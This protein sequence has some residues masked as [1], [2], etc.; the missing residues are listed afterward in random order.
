MPTFGCKCGQKIGFGEIPNPHEW[1]FISDTNFDGFSGP[2][3]S[4][5]LYRAMGSALKCP[6]CSRL[7]VFYRGLSEPPSEYILATDH[8]SAACSG[9]PEPGDGKNPRGGL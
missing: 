7:W 2:L 9:P 6:V 5:E 8:E 3:D 1:L 4:E